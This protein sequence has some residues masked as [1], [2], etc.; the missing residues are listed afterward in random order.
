MW[1]QFDFYQLTELV[2]AITTT[3]NYLINGKYLSCEQV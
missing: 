3:H 1:I 2:G